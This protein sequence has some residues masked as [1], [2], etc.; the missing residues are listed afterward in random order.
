MNTDV[1]YNMP[2]KLVWDY[3]YFINDSHLINGVDVKK[4]KCTQFD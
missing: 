3:F 4:K 1:I 2:N